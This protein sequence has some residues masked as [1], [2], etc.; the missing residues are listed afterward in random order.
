MTPVELFLCVTSSGVVL[1]A[2]SFMRW[3]ARIET[4]VEALEAA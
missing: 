3:A 4:R 2:F 1:Q